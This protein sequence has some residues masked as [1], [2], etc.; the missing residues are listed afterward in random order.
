MRANSAMK[1]KSFDRT[2][3]WLTVMAA[4]PVAVATALDYYS[5]SCSD[6][7]NVGAASRGRRALVDEQW[8]S[9]ERGEI[10]SSLFGLTVREWIILDNSVSRRKKS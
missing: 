7:S 10:A 4:P 3:S 5:T 2:C 9:N 1:T 8:G 6:A